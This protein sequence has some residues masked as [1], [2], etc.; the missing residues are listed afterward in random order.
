MIAPETMIPSIL[1][2]DKGVVAGVGGEEG[3]GL[4]G[5]AVFGDMPKGAPKLVFAVFAWDVSAVSRYLS[6]GVT[7]VHDLLFI[8][9]Y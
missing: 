4:S 6:S 8:T 9:P 1:L 7:H 2:L 5:V 3:L